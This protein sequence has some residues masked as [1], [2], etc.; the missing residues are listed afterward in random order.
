VNQN[1][2]QFIFKCTIWFGVC[3]LFGHRSLLL[4]F[5]LLGI[6]HGRVFILFLF[7]CVFES[8]RSFLWHSLGFLLLG[9]FFRLFTRELCSGS[10]DD[11]I[12]HVWTHVD[13][14]RELKLIVDL[15][16]LHC[17]HIKVKALQVHNQCV[18]Q[19][20]DSH[21]LLN[22]NLLLARLTSKVINYLSICELLQSSV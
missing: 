14:L 10:F 17:L 4:G 18:R 16:R 22:I 6:D 7:L 12:Q 19:L 2:N 15:L 20:L 8:S 13:Q 3:F 1:T 9:L 21:F 11:L 5:V